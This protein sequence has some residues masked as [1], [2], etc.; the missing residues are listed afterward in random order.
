GLGRLTGWTRPDTTTVS[1]GY[2]GAS[3]RTTVTDPTGTRTTAY[4]ARNRTVCASGGSLPAQS[5]TWTA[6][7]TLA[8]TTSGTATSSYTFDAFERMASAATPGHTDNYT[9]DGLD[10]LAQRNGVAFSYD[11]MTNNPVRSPSPGTGNPV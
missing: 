9:Y 3:N 11:D 7:G 6:R 5:W 10:R 8:S 2:D 4:D 1:Y